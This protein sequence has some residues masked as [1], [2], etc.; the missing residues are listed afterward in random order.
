MPVISIVTPS[1]NS[2]LFISN[3]IES[4]LSQTITDWEMIIVDDFSNDDSAEIVQSFVEKDHRI[5][6]IKLNR[7]LGV[8]EARNV[9]INEASGR[10]IAFLDSDDIWLPNKLE[11]QMGKFEEGAKLVFSS[12]YRMFSDGTKRLVKIPKHITY[13]KLLLGNCIGNLTASYDA[14]ALGKF[15]QKTIG[16][17]D[18]LMWLEVVKNAGFGV[19][20]QEPLACY[21]VGKGTL[22]SNKLK[23]AI[24][25]WKIYRNNLN[26]GLLKST[27]CFFMYMCNSLKKRI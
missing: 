25:T 19:G 9:A 22:S 20:I 18:Y 3:T 21:R 7:N 24:W 12:Y 26:M 11:L 5:K 17:E 14:E 8:A 1:Y 27:S 4:V 13:E 16:H 15:Y 23:S 6:L 10:Y 2:S